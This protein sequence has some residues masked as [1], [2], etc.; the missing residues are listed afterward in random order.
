MPDIESSS[1]YLSGDELELLEQQQMAMDAA[2][3]KLADDL[4]E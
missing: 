2:W 3:K 4:D 1:P